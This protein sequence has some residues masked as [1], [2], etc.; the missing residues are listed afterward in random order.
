MKADYQ[1]FSLTTGTSN[2][3]LDGQQQTTRKDEI[4]KWRP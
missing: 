1:I 3:L 2:K 4:M